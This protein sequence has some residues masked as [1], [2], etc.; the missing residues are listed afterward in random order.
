MAYGESLSPPWARCALRSRAA[1]LA[2]LS[3]GACR[4]P[5]SS[6]GATNGPG[7]SGM[8]V[9]AGPGVAALRFSTQP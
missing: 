2:W 7:S 9:T 5:G 1:A 4:K 6:A 3:D 8:S